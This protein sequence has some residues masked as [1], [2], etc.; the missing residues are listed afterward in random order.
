M[1]KINT[2]ERKGLFNI[3]NKYDVYKDSDGFYGICRE[4]ETLTHCGYKTLEA[5]LLSKQIPRITAV[6]L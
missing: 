3:N 1:Q 5:V 4:G 2:V 6:W